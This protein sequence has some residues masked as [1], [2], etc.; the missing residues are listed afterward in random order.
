MNCL[1]CTHPL[2]GLGR[3]CPACTRGLDERL[4]DL[5]RQYLLLGLAENLQ[6]RRTG[7]RGPVA[8]VRDAP[9]PLSEA[10]LTLRAEGGIVTV[11]EGW[12]RQM[13]GARG[14]GPPAEGGPYAQRVRSA[15]RGLRMSLEW[16]A[17]EWDDAGELAH[18]VR[19]LAARCRAVTDPADPAQRARLLGY[20]VAPYGDGSPC[21]GEVRLSHGEKVAECRWCG[22]TYPS[23][24]WLVL[25]TGQPEFVDAADRKS[26][27]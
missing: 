23:A 6:R 18:E 26:V 7:D 25:R 20:C 15:A 21:G 2:D 11:L 3:L 16:I 10:A 14:W 8:V 19:E 4:A 27:V 9:M 5:P 12:R 1:A 13:Q 24:T 22:C 17:A